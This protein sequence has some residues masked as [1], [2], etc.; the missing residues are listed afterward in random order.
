[1]LRLPETPELQLSS[2]TCLQCFTGHILMETAETTLPSPRDGISV[3]NSTDEYFSPKIAHKTRIS[4]HL[5]IR[6]KTA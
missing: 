4:R 6:A 2:E 1:M 3:K 5:A